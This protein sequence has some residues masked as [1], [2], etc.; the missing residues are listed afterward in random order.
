MFFFLCAEDIPWTFNHWFWSLL[1]RQTPSLGGA[2]KSHE[3]RKLP[4][5]LQEQMERHALNKQGGNRASLPLFWSNVFWKTSHHKNL[6][7]SSNASNGLGQKKAGEYLGFG[8][9]YLFRPGSIS[10]G[11]FLRICTFVKCRACIFKWR[12]GL[13]WNGWWEHEVLI[14]Q[15]QLGLVVLQGMMDMKPSFFKKDFRK[16]STQMNQKETNQIPASMEQE[17]NFYLRVILPRRLEVQYHKLHLV[18]LRSSCETGGSRC[19]RK[20]WRS[21]SWLWWVEA[22]PQP[23]FWLHPL[24]VLLLVVVVVGRYLDWTTN[25]YFG[26][27]SWISRNDLRWQT[28]FL[29]FPNERWGTLKNRQNMLSRYIYIYI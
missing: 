18:W 25:P 8:R 23:L 22:V 20:C 14:Q 3:R 29:V 7:S 28:A 24:V 9:H 26:A 6:P 13:C 1:A 2:Q 16:D 21:L 27:V 15:K 4:R 5:K 11:S 12:A 17:L 19:K 10:R